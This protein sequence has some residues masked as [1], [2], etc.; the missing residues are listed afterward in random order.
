MKERLWNQSHKFD[1]LASILVCT[2][3][4]WNHQIDEKFAPALYTERCILNYTILCHNKI[5]PDLPCFSGNIFYLM[6]FHT[7]IIQWKR[8][9]FCFHLFSE[10]NCL[11]KLDSTM[12]G[13]SCHCLLSP[14]W[15]LD[16]MFSFNNELSTN[17]ISVDLWPWFVRPLR[18][19]CQ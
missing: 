18:D 13:F 6:F 15:S 1:H 12:A 9:E 19:Q 4:F 2:A 14:F 16:N 11:F 5:C 3:R 7:C 17:V 10:L 8:S